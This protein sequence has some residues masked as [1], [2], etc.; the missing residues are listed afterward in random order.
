[1]AETGTRDAAALYVKELANVLRAAKY[2]K[3][4][5]PEPDFCSGRVMC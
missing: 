4:T 5:R 3:T 1:V 2:R